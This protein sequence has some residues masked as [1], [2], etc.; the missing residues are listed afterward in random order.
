MVNFYVTVGW[1][2]S[3]F[4]LPTSDSERQ[5]Q[6]LDG[7]QDDI[8]CLAFCPPNLLCTGAYDGTILVWNI[9]SGA[10]R[11]RLKPPAEK[12]A[13]RFHRMSLTRGWMFSNAV[14]SLTF[15]NTSVRR[16]AR[17]VV[18]NTL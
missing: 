1:S 16:D 4:L 7:H 15:L 9:V 6:R 11:F 2:R 8:L 13:A 3:V 14:E 5:V 18:R 12:S 17:L 10:L